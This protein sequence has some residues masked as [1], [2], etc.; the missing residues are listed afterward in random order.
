MVIVILK[1]PEGKKVKLNTQEDEDLYAAA[2]NPPNTGTAYTSGVDL[3]RH[4]A[5]SGNPYYY[6]QHW[7][8]W[9]GSETWYELISEE[10]AKEFLLEKAGGTY[11]TR[12]SD[13][14]RER[15]EEL[16]PGIFEEDA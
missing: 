15:A 4:V 6:L 2:R 10:E 9:Q 1:T 14:E 5:R 7:S 16:F 13:T 12:L 8:M 3:K 11:W